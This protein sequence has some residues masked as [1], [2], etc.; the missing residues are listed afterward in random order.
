[1]FLDIEDFAVFRSSVLHV[2]RCVEP[3]GVFEALVAWNDK[4]GQ[5]LLKGLPLF[6]EILLFQPL[7]MLLLLFAVVFPISFGGPTLL[8][9]GV[10]IGLRVTIFIVGILVA[11]ALELVVVLVGGR[12]RMLELL[13]V[14][15]VEHM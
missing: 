14:I 4:L 9:L 2:E 6:E 5:F 8:G 10:V 15:F 11:V 13:D 3:S 7:E 12:L 1:M